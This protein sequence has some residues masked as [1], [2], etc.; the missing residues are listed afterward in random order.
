MIHTLS[1]SPLP[2]KAAWGGGLLSSLGRGGKS[3]A[4]NLQS[5][6]C[7]LGGVGRGQ[8]AT[9]SHAHPESLLWKLW[10]TGAR[11]LFTNSSVGPSADFWWQTSPPSSSTPARGESGP[12]VVQATAPASPLPECW[13]PPLFGGRWDAGGIPAAQEHREGLLVM[14]LS[15]G[16]APPCLSPGLAAGPVSAPASL[17]HCPC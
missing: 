12:S 8:P 17:R 2:L 4:L 3:Q 10:G 13:A 11:M 9:H 14:V 15:Q 5:S 7:F 1:S 6:S 16:P